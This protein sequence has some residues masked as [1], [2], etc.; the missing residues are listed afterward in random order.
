MKNIKVYFD[1]E[2]GSYLKWYF[3]KETDITSRILLEHLLGEQEKFCFSELF[4]EKIQMLAI[5]HGWVLDVIIE[6]NL[7]N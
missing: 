7:Q 5:A 6:G 2:K 3:V 1:K 4:L